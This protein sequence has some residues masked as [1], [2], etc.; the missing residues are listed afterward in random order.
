MVETG[1]QTEPLEPTIVVREVP[2]RV[3][4]PVEV[5][6]RQLPLF[7]GDDFQAV[8]AELLVT[9]HGEHLHTNP[10]CEGLKKAR[11]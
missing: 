3:E 10:T 4:V 6:S 2:V 5:P 1:S 7:G 9:Q 11:S 8:T